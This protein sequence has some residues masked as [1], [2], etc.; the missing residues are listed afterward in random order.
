[1][2]NIINEKTTESYNC[3][4]EYLKKERQ[5]RNISIDEVAHA[6]KISKHR[7][8]SIEDNRNK[9]WPAEIYV[10]GFIKSYAEYIG[11]DTT[12]VMN[13]YKELEDKTTVTAVTNTPPFPQTTKKTK[14]SW[15]QQLLKPAITTCVILIIAAITSGILFFSDRLTEA[16]G[17]ISTAPVKIDQNATMH[18]TS[19]Q[20]Q[21]KKGNQTA[22]KENSSLLKTNI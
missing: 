3:I 20:N 1:M 11:L 4:G 22:K 10:I 19:M 2:N 14:F 15:L 6:T 13:R 9:E 5:L 12:D 7:L 17:K 8:R 16:P 18:K 21:R